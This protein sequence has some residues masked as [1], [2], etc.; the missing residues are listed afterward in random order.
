[1]PRFNSLALLGVAAAAALAT[2]ALADP[3][4]KPEPSSVAEL[5]ARVA[6]LEGQVGYLQALAQVCRVQREQNA[7]LAADTAARANAASA[8]SR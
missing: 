4:P 7:D 8:K 5:K 3:T 2:A 1:M 6:Q